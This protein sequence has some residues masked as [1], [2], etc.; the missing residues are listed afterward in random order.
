[1]FK[2]FHEDMTNDWCSVVFFTMEL[3]HSSSKCSTILRLQKGVRPSDELAGS[4]LL[5]W[6]AHIRTS[7][8][9]KGEYLRPISACIC[10]VY[11]MRIQSQICMFTKGPDTP[12]SDVST[13]RTV[14]YGDSR[15]CDTRGTPTPEASMSGHFH[16]LGYF[17]GKAC[18]PTACVLRHV[19]G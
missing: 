6:Y 13:K 1:M 3:L 2:T 7:A 8:R 15:L 14:Q 5:Q 18:T 19:V 9:T 4:S 16:F 17:M 12:L 10:I 11:N